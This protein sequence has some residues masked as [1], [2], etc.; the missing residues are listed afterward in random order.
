[1]PLPE[2]FDDPRADD[3]DASEVAG[4]A[5]PAA[6]ELAVALEAAL[7]AEPEAEEADDDAQLEKYLAKAN[8]TN[9]REHLSALSALSQQ[10]GA[11]RP[12]SPAEQTACLARY[13]A[14]V[15]ARTRLAGGR[16]SARATRAAH[17]DVRAGEQAHTELVASMFRLVLI[18]AREIAADRYGREKA[19]DILPDLVAEANLALVESVSTYDAERC[20]TFSIYAGRVIRD[21]VRMS[22]Q[23]SSAVGVAPSW[24]RLKRIYT[25]LRP[26]VE[27]SLGR[28]PN[29]EEMQQ[30]LRVVCLRWA[31][32]RLTEE[33]KLLPEDERLVLME[34]KLRKQGMLG[35]IDRLKEVLAATH[36]VASLDAPRSEDGSATLGDALPGVG[37][38]RVF[39]EV[40]HAD[41]SRDLMTALR[42][43]PEREQQ[44]V[45]H[46]FGFVDGEQWT[47]ARLAPVFGVSAERIRQIER[48]V[49]G[50]L[51]GP[52]FANLGSHLPSHLDH[53]PPEPPAGK[54]GR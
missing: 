33:Q 8:A 3:L 9:G 18:I 29:E 26:E 43:L 24:L 11:Y 52:G 7:G 21:R 44:I 27:M 42:S 54:T 2:S 22:L 40:E 51:R 45:L 34:S 39:D 12:L 5:L 38:D 28:T 31:A 53:G 32:D 50:K 30:A 19:L 37:D 25:V 10:M 23:K 48:N 41:L 15:A 49:L 16:L 4:P 1:M 6:A 20:P 47:Y 17:N 36:Q 14:G 46:R 35:A 13:E